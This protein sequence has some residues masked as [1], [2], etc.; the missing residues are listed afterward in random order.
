MKNILYKIIL[1]AF[2]AYWVITFF[3]VMPN[4]P[5]NLDSI[6]GKEVFQ[7]NFFQ[8]WAF[9]APPPTFNE[10]VYIVFKNEISLHTDVFEALEPILKAKSEKV[11]FNT[12]QQLLDYIFASTISN[13]EGNIRVFKEISNIEKSKDNSL[14]SDS[15]TLDKLVK[16]IETT[17]DFKTLKNYAKIIAK[18]NNINTDLVSFQIQ[19]VRIYIPQFVDRN[20]TEQKSEIMF[21]SHFLKF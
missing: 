2:I 14:K 11:P 3:F 10:R 17:S 9:F 1:I 21:S 7:T 19:V 16:N 18:N 6:K 8:R 15:V 5:L 12:H 13:I 4:N 20:L